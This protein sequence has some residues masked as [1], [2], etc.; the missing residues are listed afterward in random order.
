M[1]TL[2]DSKIFYAALAQTPAGCF[3]SYPSQGLSLLCVTGSILSCFWWVKHVERRPQQCVGLFDVI[4]YTEVITI[5][6]HTHR[7]QCRRHFG[8]SVRYLN[9]SPYCGIAQVPSS[10]FLFIPLS[11]WSDA[12]QSGPF[13]RL[14]KGRKGY[15]LHVLS[16]GIVKGI[17]PSRPCTAASGNKLAICIWCLKA[18]N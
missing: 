1:K 2:K 16:A 17:G 9:G 4:H 7:G 6:E 18:Q 8:I 10:A 13:K 11:D 12:G 14:Y 3:L 15:T 5:A